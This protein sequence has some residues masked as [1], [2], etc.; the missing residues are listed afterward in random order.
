MWAIWILRSSIDHYANPLSDLVAERKF[1]GLYT[2]YIWDRILPIVPRYSHKGLL[3][4]SSRRDQAPQLRPSI[5]MVSGREFVLDSDSEEAEETGEIRG[6]DLAKEHSAKHR[7]QKIGEL[8]SW[9][10]ERRRESQQLSQPTGWSV[11]GAKSV[12]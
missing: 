3:G 7:F 9:Q 1:H 5:V 2:P 4:M 11:N 10:Q 8:L 6:K 12:L